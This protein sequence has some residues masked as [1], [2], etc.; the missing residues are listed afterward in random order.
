MP[1]LAKN[2]EISELEAVSSEAM[3]ANLNIRE[4]TLGTI[5]DEYF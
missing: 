2:V 4:V 1:L 5:T 3:M